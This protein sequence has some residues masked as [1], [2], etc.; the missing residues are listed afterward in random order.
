[1]SLVD[2]L[3]Y[4]GRG[5]ASN[6]VPLDI[7]LNSEKSVESYLLFYGNQEG[8]NQCVAVNCCGLF[9]SNSWTVG[10]FCVKISRDWVKFVNIYFL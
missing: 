7:F 9:D 4:C 2:L 6:W 10:Y 5:L 3:L 1:M 8:T